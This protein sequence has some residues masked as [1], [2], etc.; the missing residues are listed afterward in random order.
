[1]LEVLTTVAKKADASKI[2]NALVKEKLAVCVSFW[3]IDSVYRWNGKICRKN[4]WHLV[5]KTQDSFK[6]P[7][8]IRLRELHPY[9]L[10]VIVACSVKVDEKVE[11]WVK[12]S[13]RK[14]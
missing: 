9:E 14:G 6:K 1:M 8:E 2:A 11:Q 7:V 3:K 4:E 12:Q 5:L 10:P 13:V